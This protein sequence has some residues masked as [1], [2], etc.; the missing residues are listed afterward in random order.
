VSY[1]RD[2]SIQL[3]ENAAELFLAKEQIVWPTDIRFERRDL[4]NRLAHRETAASE[5]QRMSA[6]ATCGRNRMLT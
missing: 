6:G 3:G 2:L 1:P 5:S 4:T